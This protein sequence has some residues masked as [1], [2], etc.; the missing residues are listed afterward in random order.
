MLRYEPEIKVACTLKKLIRNSNL[1]IGLSRYSV[2]LR[3][4]PVMKWQFV[5]GKTLPLAPHIAE[6]DGSIPRTLCAGN[7]V[8]EN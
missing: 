6:T 5:Q 4:G 3:V 1:S 2:S 8:T 7:A